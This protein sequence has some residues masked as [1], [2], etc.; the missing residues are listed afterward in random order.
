MEMQ[1]SPKG[2]KIGNKNEEARH[3]I[4]REVSLPKIKL[5]PDMRFLKRLN[6]EREKEYE[7]WLIRKKTIERIHGKKTLII[8]VRAKDGVA[9]ISDQ[10]YI[11]GGESEFESK[12]RILDIKKGVQI[13]F[14]AAGYVGATD[15]FTEIFVDVV[16]EN[17]G[18]GTINSLL[19]VKFLAEDM[20]E[21]V[22]KR[23]AVRLGESPIEFI[24]GGLSGLGKGEARL[25]NVG[26]PGYGEKI[27]SY[28]TI[29]HGSS[30]SRTL[31][32]YLLKRKGVSKLSI[33]E[34]VSRAAACIYW[35]R[36]EVDDYV[37]G[38]PQVLAMRDGNPKTFEINIERSKIKKFC[39]DVKTSLE[40]FSS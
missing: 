29:G 36:E 27:R 37:G 7:E 9:L 6:R 30:Y 1:H 11:R 20:L 4:I 8:G 5:P 40:E 13:L 28:R 18:M 15:D 22:T 23:Y 14:A 26:P 34:A 31:D 16:K 25:Y 21:D 39:K 33:K 19:S 35:I 2:R 38:E 10:K 12:V 17:V 24:F 3:R 32:R